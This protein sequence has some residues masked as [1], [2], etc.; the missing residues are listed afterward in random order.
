MVNINTA[1]TTPNPNVAH[2]NWIF[3]IDIPF[4]IKNLATVTTGATYPIINTEGI[5]TNYATMIT[6]PSASADLSFGSAVINA[7]TQGKVLILKC[8]VKLG[9]ATNLCITPQQFCQLDRHNGGQILHISRR[10]EYFKLHP[11]Y[12][13]L[14]RP[15]DW[16][17]E[18]ILWG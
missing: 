13:H 2:G 4:F 12:P 9:T 10:F 5:T 6:F 14:Y 15:Y 16:Q 17:H 3:P 1:L 11:Y 7:A 8:W 18:H